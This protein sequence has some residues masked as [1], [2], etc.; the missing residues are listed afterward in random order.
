LNFHDPTRL[1][2]LIDR[3]YLLKVTHM[4]DSK[5]PDSIDQKT[6]TE[7]ARLARL[8]LAVGSV[9]VSQQQLASILEYIGQL[10]QVDIPADTVPFFGAVEMENAIRADQ[11]SKSYP[12]EVML[13]NAPQTDG[14]YYLVPPVFG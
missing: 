12:R 7:V 6:V 14:E 3:V 4:S 10:G 11:V 9:A 13:H 5:M 1:L 8:E 2:R